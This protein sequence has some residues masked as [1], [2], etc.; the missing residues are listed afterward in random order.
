[1][2]S[3]LH[4]CSLRLPGC[5]PLVLLSF[6]IAITEKWQNPALWTTSVKNWNVRT[7]K[8]HG[9]PPEN[10]PALWDQLDL[11]QNT[12]T[13][14]RKRMNIPCEHPSYIFKHWFSCSYAQPCRELPTCGLIIFKVHQS[15]TAL[16]TNFQ[17]QLVTGNCRR[18]LIS[19][20]MRYLKYRSTCSVLKIENL[21][22]FYSKM[23]TS[24]YDK[25]EEY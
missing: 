12:T 15:A 22:C 11:Y 21:R 4:I 20:P 18:S 3:C 25:A 16:W 8:N 19:E 14:R 10:S 13:K 23:K 2:K 7:P 6:L 17:L 9:N 1:M 5:F 24:F